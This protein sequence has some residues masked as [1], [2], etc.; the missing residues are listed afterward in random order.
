MLILD[1]PTS[2]VDIHTE[3]EIM[4]ALEFLMEGRTTL[5]ISH[6]LSM[7]DICDVILELA[8]SV[9]DI[10]ESLDAV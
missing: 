9:V 4:A 3:A 10:T 2:S 6:R 5:M 1:E 8:P 7:L